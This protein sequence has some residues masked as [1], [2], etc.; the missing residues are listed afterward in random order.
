MLA[1]GAVERHWRHRQRKRG[2]PHQRQYIVVTGRAVEPKAAAVQTPVDEDPAAL[3]ANGNGDRLH[4]TGALGL[5]VPRRV[6]IEVARPQATRTVIAMRCSGRVER[7]SYAAVTAPE[8]AC[9]NQESDPFGAE[10]FRRIDISLLLSVDGA[11]PLPLGRSH[12]LRADRSTGL[13]VRP[14]DVK[15]PSAIAESPNC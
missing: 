3:A 15:G 8:R 6:A 1:L 10:N 4:A 2:Q 11:I 12:Y 9:V 14:G 13:A 5:P 7:D